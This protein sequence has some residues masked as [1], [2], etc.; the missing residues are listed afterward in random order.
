MTTEQ[1]LKEKIEKV[2][3]SNIRIKELEL[4]LKKRDDI[5]AGQD[6]EI[7]ELTA[8]VKNWESMQERGYT[9]LAINDGYIV[10]GVTVP[11]YSKFVHTQEI[12]GNIENQCYKEVNG[13]IELDIQKYKKLRRGL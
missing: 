7:N 9:A 10:E 6:T 3:K 12:P 13:K 1:R 4:S 11:A 5:I 8:I 2:R